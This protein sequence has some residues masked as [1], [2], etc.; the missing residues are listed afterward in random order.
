[1]AFIL[2]TGSPGLIRLSLFYWAALIAREMRLMSGQEQVLIV[3]DDRNSCKVLALIFERQDYVVETCST[4]QQALERA[5]EKFFNLVLLDIKLPD[6]EGVE[7]LA[8]LKRIHPDVAIIMVTAHASLETALR[9]LNEGAAAYITK[10]LN[11]DEVLSSVRGVLEKQRLRLENRRLYQTLQQELAERVQA[12]EALRKRTCDLNER[13]RELNCLY[14]ISGLLEEP[15]ISL[16]EIF[17]GAVVLI[18]PAWRHPE[19]ACARIIFEDQVFCSEGFQESACKQSSAISVNGYPCGSVEVCYRQASLPGDTGLFLEEEQNLLN[20]IARR[21][22]RAAERVRTREESQRYAERLS[23][24]RD[25]DQA[26]LVAQSS[27]AIAQAALQRIGRLVPYM[28]A[29][30]MTFDLEAKTGVTLALHYKSLDIGPPNVVGVPLQD[31]EHII[32]ELRQGKVQVVDDVRSMVSPPQ[33]IQDMQSIGMRSCISV[34]LVS[35]DELIGSINLAANTPGAFAPEHVEI[36]REVAVQLA[37]ALQQARLREQVGSHAAELE[38]RVAD[39]TRELQTLYDVT[40][41]ASESLD[42]EVVLEWTLDRSLTATRCRAGAIQLLDEDDSLRLA[43]QQG[44]PPPVEAL[45]DSVSLERSG[46]PAWIVEHSKPLI[47]P[48]MSSDARSAQDHTI[49]SF[50]YVGVPMR[51]EGRVVGVL[52]VIGETGQRLSAEEVAL[53]ASIADHVAVAVQNNHLR[54]Q[55]ERAVV[56][57]ERGRLA[58]ELHDSVTQL[59]YSLS[60]FAETGHRLAGVGAWVE[61]QDYLSR[62]SDTA[63]Q[64]LKEMRVL[65]YELRP[66]MLEQVGLLGALQGRLDAVER[67]ASVDAGLRV[68]GALKLPARVEAELYYIALEA[69]N[70]ALRH[71]SAST[72][73]VQIDA[74]DE[75]VELQVWDDGMGFDPATVGEAGGLGLIGMRE[76]AARLGGLLDVVSAPGEGTQVKVNLLL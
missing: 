24:L 29:S 61:A 26:V 67:R 4:G 45:L 75:L 20:V 32:K 73:R 28:I 49:T 56:V 47:V 14:R 15:D 12:E 64:A 17:Q 11:V 35:G 52:S 2:I 72:V 7:L 41:V 22:G 58:R 31:I 53:L 3:D 48:D 71:A 69:L 33:V 59:L 57:E 68:R 8:P 16:P 19:L 5:Q 1:V 30:I 76:R 38:R 13:V 27:Q 6:M 37:V 23:I 70:N 36:A 46:L 55:A 65:V 74:S 43:V 54:R 39:R 9:A 50:S 10:P 60:L 40:A 42:L 18:P 25:I 34:P 62:I 44:L 66:L 21:L 51:V 63:H